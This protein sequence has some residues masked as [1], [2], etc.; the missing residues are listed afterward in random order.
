M[1]CHLPSYTVCYPI[2]PSVRQELTKDVHGFKFIEEFIPKISES[3]PIL[4]FAKYLC[5]QNVALGSQACLDREKVGWGLFYAMLV[6]A[7]ACWCLVV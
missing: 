1:A 5:L 6:E 2:E 3:V 7:F 4:R